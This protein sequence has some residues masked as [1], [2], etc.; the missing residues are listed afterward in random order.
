MRLASVV[1]LPFDVLDTAL[2]IARIAVANPPAED[3]TLRRERL[4]VEVRREA[5]A[6]G[7]NTAG[8]GTAV[9]GRI[10]GWRPMLSTTASV[11]S[12][13][14]A[15]PRLRS[16]VAAR[17]GEETT[18]RLFVLGGAFTQALAQRPLG[19]FTEA[20]LH[21][22]ML[23]DAHARWT[24]WDRRGNG[25]DPPDP[26]GEPPH[27]PVP[28]P[29]GPVETT[30][31]R[32]GVLT[33]LVYGGALL[34]T[35]S[36]QR[37]LG[38]A[39]ATTA[40]PATAGRE[41]FAAMFS[42]YL[43][44]RGVVTFEPAAL[45]C[46]DRIDRV[47]VDAAVL[48]TR[49]RRVGDVLSLNGYQTDE[50][51]LRAQDLL[52]HTGARGGWEMAPLPAATGLPSRARTWLRDH[53]GSRVLLLRHGV[54]RAALVSVLPEPHPMAEALIAA[55]RMTGGLVIAGQS[56]GLTARL[57]V[58][59]EETVAGDLATVVRDLQTDGH[60]VALVS[61]Q[62]NAALVAADV[63]IGVP[64]STPPAGAD[65]IS[66]LAEACVLLAG[67]R[68]AHAAS[69]RSAQYAV[70]GSAVAG[71][72]A[73]L[74]KPDNAPNRAIMSVNLATM[75]ALAT[76]AWLGRTA[77]LAPAPAPADYT[78][79]HAMPADVVLDRLGSATEG[80]DGA[81]AAAREEPRSAVATADSL[82]HA[83]VRELDNPLTPALGASAAI[84]ASVGSTVDALLI[85]T[86]LGVNAL[87]GGVQRVRADRQLNQL[88]GIS[89]VRARVRRPGEKTAWLPAEE[90]VCGDVVTLAAGDAVPADCRLLQAD[91]LE[92]DESSLTGESGL[93]RKTAQPTAADA[94]ADRHCM[95]YEGTAVAAGKGVAVV[96]ATGERTELGRA[97]TLG[98]AGRR[99]GGVTA[100]LHALTKLAIPASIAAGVAL[101]GVDLLRGRPL[102]RALVRGISLAVAAVPEGLPFVATVAELAAARRL[103]SQGALVRNS[104]TI[105]ALGR[106]DV[107]C[108]DKTGT[109][110]EGTIA[111]R[112]VSDGRTNAAVDAVPDT[113]RPVLAAALRATP[114]AKPG[115]RTLPHP[116]DRAVTDGAHAAGVT[117]ADGLPGWHPVTALPF[118]PSRGYHAVLGQSED[119]WRLCVKGAPEVMLARC[120]HW[121]DREFD[122]AALSEVEAEINRLARHGYRVLAVAERTATDRRELRGS[123]VERLSL[124]G[125]L[126]LA[127][128]IRPTARE[129]VTTLRAAGIDVV[130]ITGDH[131]S[132]AEAIATEADA[133]NGRGVLTGPDLDTLD[134]KQLAAR[135]SDVAVFARVSPAQ[136]VRIVAAFQQAGRVVAVTGDGANDAP[137]IR[138]ADVGMALG[139]RAT[140]AARQAADVVITDDR[141]ETIADAVVEGRSMWAAVRDGL[142]IL[143]GG[144]LGE[145][146][147]TVATGLL[148][149]QETLNVRQLLLVNLLTD[150][151]PAMAVATRPPADRSVASLLAEGPDSSLGKP[152]TREITNRA[153][154]TAAAGLG[155]W[156]LT[157]LTG[158]RRQAGT[159]A[160]VALVGA[161]L[162]QTMAVR[163]RT[164]LVLAAGI[165]SMTALA[166]VVQ[167]PGISQFFGCR[168]LWPHHWLIALGASAAATITAVSAQDSAAVQRMLST[169]L[170]RITG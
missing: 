149:A 88:A 60:A 96:V 125:L 28:L 111:L 80:I 153:A 138:L 81:D 33:P 79:W 147:F 130:M 170:S 108:F 129:S 66:G 63:G 97:A 61:T 164:P 21:L 35:R 47:V 48:R 151:L 67:V 13:V 163:G 118:E 157:R 73:V 32:I 136:K 107:L 127:D 154:T 112:R 65:V 19:L 45:R 109:L 41:M 16:A 29:D 94:V 31:N 49:N 167:L 55:A 85:A 5:I 166:A 115:G 40:T 74:G 25:D 117:A 2:N 114:V 22:G 120:T 105:E 148:S 64:A 99:T 95:V 137:A 165:A 68:A 10:V 140:A 159:A 93:V 102:P 113:L 152:L 6:F 150:V 86:V 11:L 70:V 135:L 39:A 52:A 134:D 50:L 161:Q 4:R 24:T 3:T 101:L 144:N 126:A 156:I 14:D 18:D 169:I 132:T 91:N 59:E 54:E 37:A 15:T 82:L 84:S 57:D 121:G 142:S 43:T 58:A 106:V 119:G 26:P 23:L 122:A 145:I 168:P 92:V 146:A 20:C 9:A 75:L 131:P 62:D 83:T 46:L 30:A 27:R 71:L 53:T 56:A 162:G 78:P 158:A 38:L 42:R 110:T 141:I 143:L 98:D 1:S 7:A 128:P 69:T 103:S 100:R 160:L 8:F 124:V 77:A 133:L 155:T 76:G 87:I 17:L 90:L 12:W 89:S 51:S 123:R 44:D 72:L 36:Q 34:G 116:T 104:A 139:S